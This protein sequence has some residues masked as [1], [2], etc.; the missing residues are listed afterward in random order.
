M[1]KYLVQKELILF[2]WECMSA[3]TVLGERFDHAFEHGCDKLVPQAARF[4]EGMSCDAVPRTTRIPSIRSE[5]RKQCWQ[6]SGFRNALFTP[7]V[8]L[9]RSWP[10]GT[11]NGLT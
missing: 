10:V 6:L 3:Y 2:P 1:C 5:V 7:A 11:R 8:T 4:M 9:S